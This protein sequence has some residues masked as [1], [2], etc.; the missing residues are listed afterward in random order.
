MILDEL[1]Q[2]IKKIM[3]TQK[4]VRSTFCNYIEIFIWLYSTFTKRS[5]AYQLLLWMNGRTGQKQYFSV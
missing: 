3:T 2:L 4:I 5:Y 1:I